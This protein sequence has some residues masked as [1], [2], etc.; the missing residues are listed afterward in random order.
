MDFRT[1]TQQDF[2]LL[3]GAMGTQLQQYNPAPGERL[4]RWNISA[5]ERIQRVHRSYLDAGARVLYT[6]TFGA[7]HWKLGSNDASREII[8]QALHNARLAR[9]SFLRENPNENIY[10]ALDV[11]PSGELLR[12]IGT[13]DFE[14]AI[15][16]F[17]A[18]I[19][20]GYE[21]GADLIAIETM[22]DLYEMKAAIVAAREMCDLPIIAT[23][24]SMDDGRLL[25]GGDGAAVALLE[26]LRVDVFDSIAV[27]I[28]GCWPVVKAVCGF[29]PH[30][31]R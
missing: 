9:E 16:G 31:L 30:P 21:A 22:T 7:S 26:G 19:R 25:T 24:A 2:L 15:Q 13:L 10:I 1:R 18:V 8:G 29:H 17:A 5:P 20:A 12:P 27:R 23:I 4:E 6:H 14:D 3:D 11:G 28:H